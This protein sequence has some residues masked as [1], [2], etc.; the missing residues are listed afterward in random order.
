VFIEA[1]GEGARELFWHMLND[2][3]WRERGG[4]LREQSG[5][6]RRASGRNSYGDARTEISGGG[7]GSQNNFRWFGGCRRRQYR[8][9]AAV[10]NL[11]QPTHIGAS[12]APDLPD[13]FLSKALTVLIVTGL[14]DVI[15]GADLESAQSDIS[16]SL[17]QRTNHDDRNCVLGQ[18]IFER[19]KSVF[20]GHLDIESYDVG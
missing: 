7:I 13:E 12:N 3:D 16:A 8:R 5:E 6:C 10:T 17:G 11:L 14:G 1:F 2:H 4:K 9:L 19:F 18:N 15:D 20:A